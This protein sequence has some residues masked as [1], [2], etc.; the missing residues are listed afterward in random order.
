MRNGF[1][2]ILMMCVACVPV[3]TATRDYVPAPQQIAAE[4]DRVTD[5]REIIVLGSNAASVDRALAAAAPLGYVLLRTV[6][7]DPLGVGVRVLQIPEARAAAE[8]IRELEALEPGILAGVNHAFELRDRAGQVT[9]R[10]YAGTMLQWPAQGC[11]ARR[12]IGVIDAAPE[13]MQ[14]ETGTPAGPKASVVL[15]RFARGR[16]VS[17]DHGWLVTDLISDPRLLQD[18]PDLR[19]ADVVGRTLLGGEA[20]STDAIVAALAWLHSQDIRLVNVSLAGPYN[21]I[22]DRTFA[23]AAA[24]G[25]IVVA[26]AGNEGAASPPRF[27][28]AFPD[29]IAVT[30]VDA[31]GASYSRAVRGDHIEVAAP[32]VDIFTNGRYVSGTSFAAPFVTAFLAAASLEMRGVDA[33]RAHLTDHVSDGILDLRNTCP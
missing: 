6:P 32:G 31:A 29:V 7:A 28:A 16:P 9:G 27:P 33:A 18:A 4:I 8:A 25:M 30:A 24:R 2:A 20:A 23:E 1:V 15:R 21:K 12:P 14:P 3:D 17:D 26:A 10:R 5:P 22:L 11:A 19:V 13:A